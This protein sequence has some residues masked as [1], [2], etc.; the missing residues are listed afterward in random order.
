MHENHQREQY[1]W[2]P[3]TLDRL[4]DLVSTFRD[5][6]LL[7]CPMLGQH[8]WG[9]GK[10]VLT[11]DV[12]ER[13]ATLPRFVRWDLH[14]PTP[15]PGHAVP[16]LVVVDPPF[17]RVRLDQLFAGLRVLTR[18]DRSVPLLIAWPP[19][20]ATDLLGTFGAAGLRATGIRPAYVTVPDELGIEF[21]SNL[22][23]DTLA[24]LRLDPT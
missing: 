7:C 6:L 24:P 18:S 5:P 19:E 8:L 20:R 23:E 21:F 22:D 2:A 3:P 15:L 16:D 4:A 12:D 17:H 11:L 14:R 9:R 10:Q 1:F 13:F